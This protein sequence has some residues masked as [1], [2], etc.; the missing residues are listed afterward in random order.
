[1]I[2]WRAI[3]E[4]PCTVPAASIGD[5]LGCGEIHLQQHGNHGVPR[6]C[7]SG[8]DI[9]HRFVVSSYVGA[10]RWRCPHGGSGGL[11][12]PRRDATTPH[13]RCG[14]R[15]TVGRRCRIIRSCNRGFFAKPGWHI[16]PC[17]V[18][19]NEAV[20]TL[21]YSFILPRYYLSIFLFLQIE[22]SL[23]Y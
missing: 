6:Q 5:L 17:A 13:H 7:P 14:R 9:S 20:T 23:S 22:D 3:D 12:A 16:N 4:Q 10:V 2:H 21:F 18:Q 15:T 11:A 19:G 1:M 8:D